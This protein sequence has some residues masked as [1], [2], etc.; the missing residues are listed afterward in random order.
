[1]GSYIYDVS[2]EGERGIYWVLD[3]LD[4]AE[5]EEDRVFENINIPF[6]VS[7]FSYM[8]VIKIECKWMEA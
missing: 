5:G 8:Q 7:N 1:M 2:K 6:L 3:F 4:D